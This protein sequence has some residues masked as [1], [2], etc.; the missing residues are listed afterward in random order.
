MEA[1]ELHKLITG[2]LLHN[3][4][5]IAKITKEG[6]RSADWYLRPIAL[7]DIMYRDLQ[8][9]NGNLPITDAEARRWV[10]TM[11]Y[12]SQF[13]RSLYV[14][15]SLDEIYE[16]NEAME[17]METAIARHIPPLK[18]A[19]RNAMCNETSEPMLLDMICDL[20]CV[21]I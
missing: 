13:M 4:N 11:N 5:P 16:L 15:M 8:E 9:L 1:N 20:W 14:G 10:R 3:V 18:M 17:K 21:H 7:F 19:M 6:D 2:K 12:C